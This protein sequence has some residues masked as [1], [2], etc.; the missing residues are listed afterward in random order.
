MGVVANLKERWSRVD[1]PLLCIFILAGGI[2]TFMLYLRVI[3]PM[4]EARQISPKII[5][6]GE[7]V[8]IK[9]HN[10]MFFSNSTVTTTV[11]IYQVGGA[12]SATIGDDSQLKIE[13]LYDKRKESFLCIKSE[14]KTDCYRI[15]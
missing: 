14:V 5:S 1:V 9:A 10:S 8:D 12:V 3:S 15:L 7:V 6:A 2:S 13:T 4:I 11:G